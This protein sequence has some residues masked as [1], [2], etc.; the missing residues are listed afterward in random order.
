M[1]IQTQIVIYND[2][3]NLQP[4]KEVVNISENPTEAPCD[5]SVVVSSDSRSIC[6]EIAGHTHLRKRSR[7]SPSRTLFVTK[8]CLLIP[9]LCSIIMGFSIVMHGILTVCYITNELELNFRR[10]L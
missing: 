4:E 8:I 5:D 3:L 1:N 9:A 6:V 2:N 10:A 7:S